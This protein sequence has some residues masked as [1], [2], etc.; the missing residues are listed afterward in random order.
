MNL[1]WKDY[2]ECLNSEF[3]TSTKAPRID[4]WVTDSRK[5]KEGDWFVPLVGE[6]Y[7]G[8]KFI[9]SALKQG[10]YGFVYEECRATHLSSK[11]KEKG[12]LVQD[13]LNTFQNLARI[14]RLKNNDLTLFALTGSVGKT[15]TKEMLASVLSAIDRNTFA[16][17]GNFNNEVGVPMTLQ[18][19]QE[20][21]RYAVVEM[22]AR[23]PLDIS[24]LVEIARPNITACLNAKTAHIEIFKTKEA[25]LDTKLEIFNQT[26]QLKHIVFPRDDERIVARCQNLNLPKTSFGHHPEA[27]IRLKEQTWG[28]DGSLKV[29]IS[30]KNQEYSLYF[31]QGHSAY[32]INAAAALAMGSAAGLGMNKMV[33]TLSS[34]TGLKGRF[35][36]FRNK[37]LTIIDDC[38]NANPDSM[39]EG[40]NTLVQRYPQQPKVLILG[41]MLELGQDAQSEHGEIG[42]YCQALVNP[43]FLIGIGEHSQHIIDKAISNGLPKAQTLSYSDVDDFLRAHIDLGS[44]GKVVFVKGSNGVRLDRV[45]ERYS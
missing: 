20:G 27:D 4:Q 6:N 26:P 43:L 15:T 14:W 42:S 30:F 17:A 31:A 10:A 9:D 19:I 5:I 33:K 41:D 24:K 45:I 34:F 28:E 23:R 39:K 7:D 13:T 22:G 8:H 1:E 2:A 18:R 12:I 38:Y 21:H 36:V 25:I 3:N 11:Q 16:T 37:D 29:L 32:P 40:I 44:I 35:N